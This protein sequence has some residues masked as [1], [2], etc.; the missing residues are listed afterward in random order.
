MKRDKA[1]GGRDPSR[2]AIESRES[3][4]NRELRQ[5]K[6]HIQMSRRDANPAVAAAENSR[7]I[8]GGRFSLSQ[9]AAQARPHVRHQTKEPYADRWRRFIAWTLRGAGV[10]GPR[11][12]A[13]VLDPPVNHRHAA[14]F[15]WN[16]LAPKLRG[17]IT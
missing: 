13:G 7:E 8:L 5:I 6:K 16:D 3:N 10:R 11:R 9:G 4:L 17:R 12:P 14:L 15:V 1:S 2:I